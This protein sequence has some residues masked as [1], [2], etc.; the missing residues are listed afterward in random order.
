MG[1]WE[2]T[3]PITQRVAAFLILTDCRILCQQ[4]A[5]QQAAENDFDFKKPSLLAV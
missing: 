2:N 3:F 1:D 4:S 5:Q